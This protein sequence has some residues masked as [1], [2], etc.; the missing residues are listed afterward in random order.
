MKK[1]AI[2]PASV[3]RLISGDLHLAKY[4]HPYEPTRL[5]LANFVRA[6]GKTE[7]QAEN[8]LMDKLQAL[9]GELKEVTNG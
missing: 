6:I 5:G 2:N 9:G 7:I 1:F 3:V 4:P 8:L